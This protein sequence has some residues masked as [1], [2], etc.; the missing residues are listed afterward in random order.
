MEKKNYWGYRAVLNKGK[1]VKIGDVEFEGEDYLVLEEIH[2]SPDDVPECGDGGRA[3]QVC[4]EEGLEG[5][6]AQLEM[7]IRHLK[8]RG[9]LTDFRPEE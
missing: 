9:I 4:A 5:M 3:F 2:Y 1:P 6:I 8:E 7:T